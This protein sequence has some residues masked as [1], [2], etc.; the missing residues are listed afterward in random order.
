ARDFGAPIG[1]VFS[2]VKVWNLSIGGAS[3]PTITQPVSN[4]TINTT[5]AFVEWNGG[6]HSRYQVR[7]T[8]V[9]DPDSSIAWDSRDV[10]SDR[11]FAWT[12]PLPDLTTYHLFARLG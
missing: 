6:P 1:A 11:N 2:N 3:A 8:H 12:G 10:A 4:A 5:V 9:N 7:V